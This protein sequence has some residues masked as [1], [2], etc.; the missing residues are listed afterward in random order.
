MEGLEFRPVS[1]VIKASQ[2]VY[3]LNSIHHSHPIKITPNPLIP[4]QKHPSTYPT[5]TPKIQPH[6]LTSN[7]E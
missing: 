3:L 4:R 6:M 5:P 1:I 7:R 2:A